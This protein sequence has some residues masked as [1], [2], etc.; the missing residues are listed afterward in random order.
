MKSFR[1]FV[2]GSERC[3]TVEELEEG[4]IRNLGAVASFAR[5]VSLSKQIK[6][7]KDVGEKIDLL[8]S[9]QTYLGALAMAVGEFLKKPN[10]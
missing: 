2:D 6:R 5:I 1:E 9:Q 3:E 10:R 7:T 4:A 8:A